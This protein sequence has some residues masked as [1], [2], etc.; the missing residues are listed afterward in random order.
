MVLSPLYIARKNFESHWQAS[1]FVATRETKPETTVA[2]IS[3]TEVPVTEGRR[4]GPKKGP[5]QNSRATVPLSLLCYRGGMVEFNIYIY[6]WSRREEERPRFVRVRRI[7]RRLCFRNDR[8]EFRVNRG[9]L[10][11]RVLWV[12]YGKFLTLFK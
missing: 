12:V 7:I 2:C 8:P 5:P 10:L 3:V 4:G 9:Y 1:F 11:I 6:T